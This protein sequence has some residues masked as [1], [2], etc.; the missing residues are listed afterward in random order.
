MF[1]PHRSAVQRL[2]GVPDA[3]PAR[4]AGDQASEPGVG[5]DR[6]GGGVQGARAEAPE[7]GVRE[8]AE[9]D[10]LPVQQAGAGADGLHPFATSPSVYGIVSPAH[11]CVFLSSAVRRST[12]CRRRRRKSSSTATVCRKKK[13]RRRDSWKT[14]PH[15][16]THE[17]SSEIQWR[18]SGTPQGRLRK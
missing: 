17:H 6:P 1:C 4:E 7:G 3:A 9:I 5:R 2:R 8:H 12:V 15:R 11:C 10:D 18:A 13:P 16:C 14:L